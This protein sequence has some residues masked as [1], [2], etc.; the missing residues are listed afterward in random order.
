M[1]LNCYEE[2]EKRHRKSQCGG[3]VCMYVNEKWCHPNNAVIKRHAC[4]LYIHF[5]G[6]FTPILPT[7]GIFSCCV[8]NDIHSKPVSCKAGYQWIVIHGIERSNPDALVITN[9]DFNHASL[10]KSSVQYH[11]CQRP[12]TSRTLK[13]RILPPHSLSW[14]KQTTM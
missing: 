5:Y 10:K 7:P 3:G 4:S 13:K 6:Q 1:G 12:Y 14:V 9:G 2:I 11:Q 8:F